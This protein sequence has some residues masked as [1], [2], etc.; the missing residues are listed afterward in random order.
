MLPVKGKRRSDLTSTKPTS[1]LR[2]THS[3]VLCLLERG[4]NVVS[5]DLLDG[6][7]NKIVTSRAYSP[8]SLLPQPSAACRDRRV[9]ELDSS[10]RPS[11]FTSTPS[12][13]NQQ[14]THLIG[15]PS[16]QSPSSTLTIPAESSCSNQA[17]SFLLNDSFAA[18]LVRSRRAEMEKT[19]KS[20]TTRTRNRRVGRGR[21]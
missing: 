10:L 15:W 8:I 5:R 12:K 9:C 20:T 7:K 11:S 14:T 3:V 4:R 19:E 1:S 16:F 21:C 13:A 17:R 18:L 6:Y 2:R